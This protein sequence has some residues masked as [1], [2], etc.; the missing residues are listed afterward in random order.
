MPQLN[1]HK[2]AQEDQNPGR[3]KNSVLLST[4]PSGGTI[5]HRAQRVRL[6]RASHSGP[7]GGGWN[8]VFQGG[9]FNT[10]PAEGSGPRNTG[11][12]RNGCRSRAPTRASLRSAAT[13]VGLWVG[14]YESRR[15]LKMVGDGIT[16]A[17]PNPAPG[18]RALPIPVS[19]FAFKRAL[20]E[21][22][23]VVF[24]IHALGGVKME[25]ARAA[26]GRS[27]RHAEDSPSRFHYRQDKSGT[28]PRKASSR[29][30]RASLRLTPGKNGRRP[31]SDHYP[32]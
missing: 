28:G 8:Y 18:L 14:C 15:V 22:E 27:G 7:L 5:R 20:T 31:R 23:T 6:S 4:H 13:A 30:G 24:G 26:H 17:M 21:R 1:C 3:N 19:G 9:S 12:G 10:P 2:K 16:G 11:F 29:S 32:G 25:S